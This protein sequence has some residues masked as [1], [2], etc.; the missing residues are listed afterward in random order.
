MDK[1]NVCPISPEQL[2]TCFSVRSQ[3]SSLYR[4]W[5][6]WIL[7]ILR[8][9]SNRSWTKTL[10]QYRWVWGEYL[11]ATITEWFFRLVL[12]VKHRSPTYRATFSM[13]HAG[14]SRKSPNRTPWVTPNQKNLRCLFTPP[15]T[16]PSLRLIW[17]LTLDPRPLLTDPSNARSRITLEPIN[18][19]EHVFPETTTILCS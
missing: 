7:R 9:L 18:G 1:Q 15:R 6:L 3:S 12:E 17:H 8:G 14:A 13:G 16:G 2:S 19:A 4:E 11:S 5:Q 10:A